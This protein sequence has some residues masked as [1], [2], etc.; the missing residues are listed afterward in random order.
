MAP[1][2]AVI[3]VLA[4]AVVVVV[5]VDGNLDVYL[6]FFNYFILLSLLKI[7]LRVFAPH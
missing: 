6:L 7:P 5:F 1:Y 4:F 2:S 3:A